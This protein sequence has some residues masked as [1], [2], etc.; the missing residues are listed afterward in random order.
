MGDDRPT[1]ADRLAH[2]TPQD[3]ERESVAVVLCEL[4]DELVKATTQQ[5]AMLLRVLTS[6]LTA[7]AGQTRGAGSDAGASAPSGTEGDDT[8]GAQVQLR[9]P[10]LPPADPDAEPASGTDRPVAEPTADTKPAARKPAAKT[11][12]AKKATAKTPTATREG[13]TTEQ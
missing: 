9:E 3:R 4:V 8:G 12:A 5:N 6:Q 13:R 2:L 1:L 11:T 10:G 7:N